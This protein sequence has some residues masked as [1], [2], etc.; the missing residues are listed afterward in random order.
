MATEKQKRLKCRTKEQ[1]RAWLLE[2]E[3]DGSVAERLSVM[4]YAIGYS[5]KVLIGEED[6]EKGVTQEHVM[7]EM[8]WEAEIINDL[9]ADLER[10]IKRKAET[11]D[12]CIA[13]QEDSRAA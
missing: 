1:Y 10:E 11:V 9:E 2:Y 13:D 12:E 3:E 6:E 8:Q 7:R 4:Q 5:A